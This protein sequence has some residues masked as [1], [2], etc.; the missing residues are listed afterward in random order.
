MNFFKRKEKVDPM[1]DFI[2]NYNKVNSDIEYMEKQ[3]EEYILKSLEDDYVVVKDKLYDGGYSY[4]FNSSSMSTNW[5][6]NDVDSLSMTL[7]KYQSPKASIHT[8]KRIKLTFK[9]N[10]KISTSFEINYL[11]VVIGERTINL[12]K[13]KFRNILF[14]YHATFLIEKSKKKLDT[15]KNSFE[16]LIDVV[17]QEY[18]RD[19]KIDSIIN[20]DKN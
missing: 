2:N 18:Y 20:A 17:G 9:H 1:S 12:S 4:G 5:T 7:I 15:T 8:Y 3:Y 10:G 11:D 14:K 6:I 13:D 16:T 19:S